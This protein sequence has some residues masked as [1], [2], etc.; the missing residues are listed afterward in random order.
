MTFT[1]SDRSLPASVE[2]LIADMVAENKRKAQAAVPIAEFLMYDSE[3]CSFQAHGLM[4][5]TSL[6]DVDCIFTARNIHH[7]DDETGITLDSRNLRRHT[8]AGLQV[9]AAMSVVEVSL[10][11]QVPSHRRVPLAAALA[12]TVPPPGAGPVPAAGRA[13]KNAFTCLSTWSAV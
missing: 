7:H 6:R 5:R 4:D 9:P 12:V 13:S 1:T 8:Q 10:I 3:S 2:Q 11:V